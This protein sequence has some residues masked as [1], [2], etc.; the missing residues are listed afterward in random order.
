LSILQKKRQDVTGFH[1]DLQA[2]RAEE[3]PKVFTDMKI[4][5]HITGRDIDPAAVE[6]A[7]EL[8]E[9]KYC[10]AQA[11]FQ[12]ILPIELEYEIKEAA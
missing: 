9:T 8:S 1:V 6:R 11:M 5:Y 2:S 12:D 3:H 7:I 10:P 4:T